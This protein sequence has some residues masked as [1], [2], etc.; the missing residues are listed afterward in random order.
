MMLNRDVERAARRAAAAMLAAKCDF[1][2]RAAVGVVGRVVAQ[3][4]VA[5]LLASRGLRGALGKLL[6][7]REQKESA[8]GTD[9]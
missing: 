5:D 6:T 3:A 4:V 7:I 1:V 2:G 9:I 8:C